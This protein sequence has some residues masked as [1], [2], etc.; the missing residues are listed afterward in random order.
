[1]VHGHRGGGRRLGPVGVVDGE[2]HQARLSAKRHVLRVVI[3]HFHRQAILMCAG[4][5]EFGAFLADNSAAGHHHLARLAEMRR[6]GGGRWSMRDGGIQLRGL[7]TGHDNIR[8]WN[9]KRAG[10]YMKIWTRKKNAKKKP[11]VFINITFKVTH[12][13]INQ[14]INKRTNT[15]SINQSIDKRTNNHSINQSIEQSIHLSTINQ[16]IDLYY[17]EPISKPRN[18]SINADRTGH[19]M[20]NWETNRK[21]VSTMTHLE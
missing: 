4:N 16:S 11:P 20:K 18:Q 5:G 3:H 7:T 15:H 2:L 10:E 8:E 1:M 6:C 19:D 21:L 13:S 17:T 14:S 12:Q 9:L